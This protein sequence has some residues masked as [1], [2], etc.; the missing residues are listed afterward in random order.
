M[1]SAKEILVGMN[2]TKNHSEKLLDDNLLPRKITNT[3]TNTIT[4][5]VDPHFRPYLMAHN[6][7]Y[8]GRNIIKPQE[9]LYIP[10]FYV[11][12]TTDDGKPCKLFQEF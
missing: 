10:H 11:I 3:G 7:P 12:L 4:I 8:Q 6:K 5:E 2:L 1:K 9:F